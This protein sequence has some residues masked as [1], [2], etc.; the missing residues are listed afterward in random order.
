MC[1]TSICQRH[2]NILSFPRFHKCEMSVM[3]KRTCK[4]MRIFFSSSSA[5][6]NCLTSCLKHTNVT[7]SAAAFS[8]GPPSGWF[9]FRDAPVVALQ[10]LHR[11]SQ[12]S[13]LVLEF[14]K[15]C[16]S[17]RWVPHLGGWRQTWG[18]RR[19]GRAVAGVWR[20]QDRRFGGQLCFVGYL[21]AENYLYDVYSNWRQ[22][23][24][25]FFL[26]SWNSSC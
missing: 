12:V 25:T 2:I 8:H 17:Q 14:F 7:M 24:S 20:G 18:G 10:Q 19:G 1:S 5:L 16:W 13:Q 22:I 11:G 9:V 26:V 3:N 4:L 15:H 6:D 21:R 23:R